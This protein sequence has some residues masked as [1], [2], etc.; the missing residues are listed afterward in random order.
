MSQVITKV[1]DGFQLSSG[2]QTVPVKSAVLCT[3]S[4]YLKDAHGQLLQ[5][6]G[7]SWIEV[8]A[9]TEDLIRHDS[10]LF[11]SN[12]LVGSCWFDGSVLQLSDIRPAQK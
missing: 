3:Q 10:F 4:R 9:N 2:E 1:L 12:E 7:K 6:R 5:T 11:S 8:D